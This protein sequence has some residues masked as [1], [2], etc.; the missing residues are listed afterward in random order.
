MLAYKKCLHTFYKKI[1]SGT[2]ERDEKRSPNKA[3][4]RLARELKYLKKHAI[5]E[6]DDE[7]KELIQ[8][9]I[10][11]FT[12]DLDYLKILAEHSEKDLNSKNNAILDEIEITGNQPQLDINDKPRLNLKEEATKF[13]KEIVDKKPTDINE[14]YF[15]RDAMKKLIPELNKR[16]GVKISQ[17]NRDS[18][19]KY[20][21]EFKA[22]YLI[23]KK[24]GRR[25]KK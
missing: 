24:K 11:F 9:D 20:L 19:R 12:P 16:P 8:K 4:I 10:N 21:S 17:G 22:S 13:A 15:V 1:V 18:I 5:Y 23:E 14:T 2:I 7:Q 6:E 3:I 25:K